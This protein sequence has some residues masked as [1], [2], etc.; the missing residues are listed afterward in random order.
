MLAKVIV[1]PKKII[2]KRSFLE[3]LMENALFDE[4]E[5]IHTL[6]GRLLLNLYKVSDGF[7]FPSSK[8]EFPFEE[9]N[10]FLPELSS[11]EISQLNKLLSGSIFIMR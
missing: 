7:A 2:M 6:A 9:V 3:G 1:D 4:K 10:G 5:S 11:Q 8:C